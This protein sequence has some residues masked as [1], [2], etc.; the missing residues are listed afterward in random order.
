M[1]A[2]HCTY[3]KYHWIIYFKNAS[4]YFVYSTL[5]QK[6]SD[7]ILFVQV[8][9]KLDTS[10][11][12]NPTCWWLLGGQ[13]RSQYLWKEDKGRWGAT[14]PA[15]WLWAGRMFFGWLDH[16]PQLFSWTLTGCK[17]KVWGLLKWGLS[18]WPRVLRLKQASCLSPQVAE[19]IGMYHCVWLLVKMSYKRQ[20]KSVTSWL[21]E[22]IP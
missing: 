16:S 20:L 19:V 21:S 17:V 8:G 3:F 9:L 7:Q 10:A 18:M 4:L 1:V 6:K 12:L 11:A 14:E 15:V 2:Q 22:I 13:C 5:L